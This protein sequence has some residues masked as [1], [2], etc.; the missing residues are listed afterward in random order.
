M[1]SFWKQS[2]KTKLRFPLIFGGFLIFAFYGQRNFRQIFEKEL[3]EAREKA[4]PTV[5]QDA[6]KQL[7]ALKSKK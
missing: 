7:E 6:L 4:L 2:L 5:D 3:R 1:P